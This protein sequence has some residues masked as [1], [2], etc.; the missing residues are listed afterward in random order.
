MDDTW[1]AAWAAALDELE[2]S[3]DQAEAL[4]HSAAPEPEPMPPWE[5]PTLQGPPPPQQL[6]R[7][8]LL[9]ERHQRVT[10]ELAQAM[11]ASRQ[12]LALAGRMR[13]NRP[14]ETPVYLDLHA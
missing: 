8:H 4:L 7:A 3:V 5:P 12:Q 9:L 2:L 10:R 14:R 11:A 13:Q 1:D 6:R